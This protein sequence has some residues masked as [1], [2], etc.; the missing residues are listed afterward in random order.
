VPQDAAGKSLILQANEPI[1]LLRTGDKLAAALVAS[2]VRLYRLP[3]LRAALTACR[4]FHE[5]GAEGAR[6]AGPHY[7][8][9]HRRD[10]LSRGVSAACRRHRRCTF[11]AHCATLTLRRFES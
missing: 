9:P 2:F 3:A 11:L 10:D 7:I 8:T 1:T 6:I 4:Q 5:C